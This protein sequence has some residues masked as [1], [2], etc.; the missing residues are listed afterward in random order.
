MRWAAVTALPL[1]VTAGIMLLTLMKQLDEWEERLYIA[2]LCLIYVFAASF[3]AVFL[4]NG[5][6]ETTPPDGYS[7][8][9]SEKRVEGAYR[10]GTD[11]I[12]RVVRG[13]GQT[14]E[15]SVLAEEYDSVSKGDPVTIERH[16]GAFGM[17]YSRLRIDKK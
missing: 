8:V 10:G 6:L 4:L 1:A 15:F 12:L 9:I 16:S 13:N 7:A 3:G 2:L 14:E 5:S 17:P 11:Y